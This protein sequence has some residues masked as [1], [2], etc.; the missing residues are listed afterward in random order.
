MPEKL[1]K[2]NQRMQMQAAL[3]NLP[4]PMNEVEISMPELMEEEADGQAPLEEDP[5]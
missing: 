2:A 3:G 1:R 4:A 5:S